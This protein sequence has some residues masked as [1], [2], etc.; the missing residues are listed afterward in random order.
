MFAINHAATALLVKKRFPSQP[1][2]WL[3]L[4]VQLMELLWLALNLLGVERTSTEDSVRSVSDIH[5]T[6]MPWSHS[7]ATM[8]GVALLAWLLLRYGLRRPILAVAVAIGIASHLVLDL[9]THAQDIVL[10]PG[11]PEPRLGL[12][13]YSAFP[14]GAFVLELAYGA[15]CWWVYRGGRAL[16]AVILLFNLANLSMLSPAIPGPETWLAHRPTAIVLVIA[17]QIAV[18]LYLV[19]RFSGRPDPDPRP[20]G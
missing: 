3:L 11:I 15:F 20:A 17:A 5:L 1:M 12:G 14:I 2:V 4:S 13:L 7:V 6:S 18:T 16:L 10:A 8:L 19:G 9:V